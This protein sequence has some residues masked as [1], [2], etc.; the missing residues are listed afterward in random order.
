MLA[1]SANSL[2][3]KRLRLVALVLLAS[4]S[5]AC[6][7]PASGVPMGRKLG[8]LNESIDYYTKNRD[9]A[10][11]FRGIVES[12]QVDWN[13]T[14][15]DRECVAASGSNP[16][17]TP[18]EVVAIRDAK[19]VDL[20]EAYGKGLVIARMRNLGDCVESRYGLQPYQS[21]LEYYFVVEPGSAQS[22]T[23]RLKLVSL[24]VKGRPAA[25]LVQKAGFLRSC[26]HKPNPGPPSTAEFTGCTKRQP[27]GA[28]GASD[29]SINSFRED[30][31]IS[32]I[33]GCC[34]AEFELTT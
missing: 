1:P 33:H 23:A 27:G 30:A 31:W 29:V 12:K 20:G 14:T 13:G 11:M 22:E 3:N 21:G 25:V 15:S 5:A 10:G 16:D 28:V 9:R 17:M 7:D 18:V 19:T 4:A 26:G 24:Q 32:C 2:L 6:D 8:Q 34:I